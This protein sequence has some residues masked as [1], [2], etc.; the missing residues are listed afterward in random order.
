MLSSSRSSS[1]PR[2]VGDLAVTEQV[3]QVSTL[4]RD[5]FETK[6][7]SKRCKLDAV[8]HGFRI[9]LLARLVARAQDRPHLLGQ[10]AFACNF[11]EPPQAGVHGLVARRKLGLVL[12]P[13]LGG[14]VARHAK[15]ADHRRERQ[16]KPHEGH[17]DDPEGDE[18]DRIAVRKRLPVGERERDGERRGERDHAAARP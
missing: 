3:E 8:V 7:G 5:Q 1:A 9:L 12:A 11:F 2:L 17:D 18:E 4:Y 15:D 13:V 14:A 6:L 16:A 10:P